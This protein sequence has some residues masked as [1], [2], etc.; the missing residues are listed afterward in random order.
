MNKKYYYVSVRYDDGTDGFGYRYISDDESLKV[1]DRVLV[2]RQNMLATGRI[3]EAKFY[4]YDEVPYPVEYTKKIIEKIDESYRLPENTFKRE[5]GSF[6]DCL[7]RHVK[8]GKLDDKFDVEDF[9]YKNKNEKLKFV[10]GLEENAFGMGN[11]VKGVEFLEKKIESLDKNNI[12]KIV[13]EIENYFDKKR[14]YT[15]DVIIPIREYV[16]NNEDTINFD[17]LFKLGEGLAIYPHNIEAVKLGILILSFYTFDE[18]SPVYGLFETF[19]YVESLGFYLASLYSIQK[20]SQNLLISAAKRVI[21]WGRI[22]YIRMLDIDDSKEKT[23]E[24]ILSE[25]YYNE[26]DISEISIVLTSSVDMRK[27]LIKYQDNPEMVNG[28]FALVEANGR[29]SIYDWEDRNEFLKTLLGSKEKFKYNISF[30]NILSDYRELINF[31]EYTETEE[32]TKL[33]IETEK[34]Y[35]DDETSLCLKEIVKNGDDSIN[36][37]VCKFLM[38]YIGY[39]EHPKEELYNYYIKHPTALNMIFSYLMYQEEY[40]D[41]IYELGKKNIEIDKLKLIPSPEKYYSE[42][43]SKLYYLITDLKSYPFFGEDMIILG[44]KCADHDVRYLAL[45][46]IV[47]WMKKTKKKYEDFSNELKSEIESLRKMEMI[48]DNKK[49]INKI[50]GEKENL[51]GYKDPE[52]EIIFGNNK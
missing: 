5:P 28:I 23:I 42:E 13:K 15:K 16:G 29:W 36:C 44:L 31:D 9:K 50:T 4:Q 1:G 7:Y 43:Y 22:D 52:I 27:L 10:D 30:Y 32:E 20:D 24:W 34:I 38:S 47:E 12:N 35:R 45:K 19:S 25:G 41:E 40:R 11:D 6:Y 49:L 39:G 8:N 33:L 46:A 18:D 21:G 51:K 48:K 37:D 26:I 17:N 3:I 14:L 2:E